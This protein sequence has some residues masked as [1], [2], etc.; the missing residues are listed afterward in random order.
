MPFNTKDGIEWY[1]RRSD[2]AGELWMKRHGLMAADQVQHTHS[3]RVEMVDDSQLNAVLAGVAAKLF[4]AQPKA[5]P[6]KVVE[7]SG[8]GVSK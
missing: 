3:G 5:I 1:K 6:G 7:E 8:E 4:G 2:K